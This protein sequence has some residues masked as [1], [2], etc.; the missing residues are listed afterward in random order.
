[1]L[2]NQIKLVLGAGQARVAK[3]EATLNGLSYG[4]PVLSTVQG[5]QAKMGICF[6]VKFPHENKYFMTTFWY[7]WKALSIYFQDHIV[8]FQQQ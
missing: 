2:Y 5:A 1:L 7:H 4:P 8:F 6:E 3:K